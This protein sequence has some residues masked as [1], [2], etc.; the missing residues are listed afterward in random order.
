M[1]GVIQA[2]ATAACW[3]SVLAGSAQ[4]AGAQTT[5]E[6]T[7]TVR[8]ATSTVVPGVTVTL[9]GK[10]LSAPVVIE[11]DH[12]GRFAIRLAP[13]LYQVATVAAGFLPWFTEVELRASGATLDISLQPLSERVTVTATRT[14]TADIQTTGVAITALDPKTLDQATVERIEHLTG[15]VPTL[16]ISQSAGGTPLLTLRG[17]GSN[18]STNGAD[19]SVTMQ[20]DGVY[21]ARASMT[22]LD[23]LDVDRVEVLR[24]P[25]GTLIGRN[26]IGGTINVVTRQPTNTLQARARLTF[27]NYDKIRAE[28]AVSGPLL[29]NRIMGAFAFLASSPTSIIRTTRWAATTPGPDVASCDSYSD[30]AASCWSRATTRVLEVLH[31]RSPGRSPPRRAHHPSTFQLTSGRSAR[32]TWQRVGTI[33]V[34]RRHDSRFKWPTR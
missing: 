23:F 25:Q 16:A 19:P 5:G 18:A 24:G 7:G 1:I 32:A 21:L 12:Q 14:G 10:T 31:L 3:G 20:L 11:T 4:V 15:L 22:A 28:G 34:G 33:R 13:G 6:L 29:R 8:D 17:I 26:S 30:R 9:K 2:L 27:G